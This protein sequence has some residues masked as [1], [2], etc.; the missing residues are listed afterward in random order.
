MTRDEAIVKAAAIV[1][2]NMLHPDPVRAAE[3]A[4]CEVDTLVVLGI[5][6]LDE[7][8]STERQVL[9]IIQRHVTP[10]QMRSIAGAIKNA[11]VL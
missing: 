1:E 3:I 10:A 2:P 11:D 8:K 9:D 6:K 4:S 7:P 5:L